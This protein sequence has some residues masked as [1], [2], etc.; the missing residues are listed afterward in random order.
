MSAL[1]S[2]RP[3]VSL[4]VFVVAA[5]MCCQN[6]TPAPDT[7]RDA[8]APEALPSVEPA[9]GMESAAA[10]GS[11]APEASS[12]G[13]RDPSDPGY[14]GLTRPDIA[15]FLEKLQTA[16]RTADKN[17]VAELIRYPIS[18]Y[19]GAK[20]VSIASPEELIRN[21]DWI[22][23]PQLRNVLEEATPAKLFANSG[24][25]MIGRGQ[26]WFGK[27]CEDPRCTKYTVKVITINPAIPPGL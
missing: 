8:S 25:V 3:V 7:M 15:T 2:R 9:Q 16:V 6:R 17:K 18:A 1:R 14:A 21:Y 12:M 13:D 5:L 4:A 20:L 10:N 23:Y 11:A 19:R 26:I 27:I 22:F 24:G